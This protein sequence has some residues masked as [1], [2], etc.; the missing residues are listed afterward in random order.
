MSSSWCEE[1]L[2]LEE[3]P[4]FIYE[5]EGGGSTSLSQ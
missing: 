3:E 1:N 4:V 2:Q 5:K